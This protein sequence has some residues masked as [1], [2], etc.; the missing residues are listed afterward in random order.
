MA[1]N[2]NIGGGQWSRNEVTEKCEE[3]KEPLSQMEN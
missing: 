3:F 2:E 1:E